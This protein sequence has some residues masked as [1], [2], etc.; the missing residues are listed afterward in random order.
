MC[1]IISFDSTQGILVSEAGAILE[2][3]DNFL[4]ERGFIM[5]LDLGAKG[6]CQIGGNVA[7]NAGGLRLLRYGS[8]HGTVLSLEVV[9]PNGT[10]VE[11]GKP[12]RKDNTGYDLKQLFIGSEGTL[13]IISKV[14]ILTPPMPKATTV[15]IV[16][17]DSYERVCQIFTKAK[18][19]LGEILSAFE[20]FDR[21][22]VD[23]VR[24]HFALREPLEQT[25]AFYVLIETHGSN[26]DHDEAKLSL[27][28]ESLLEDEAISDGVLAQD[29]EQQKLFWQIRESITEACSKEGGLYK[30]DLSVPVKDLYS[31]VTEMRKVLR[32][33]G[34]YHPEKLDSK[35]TNI[36]GFGH[37]GDGNLH[38]NINAT[39]RTYEIESQIEPF[40]YE[41]V[42]RLNGSISAEHGLGLMK[43]PFLKYSKNNSMINIMKQIKKM[44]DPKGI[45]NPY[46]YF[47]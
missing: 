29:I 46:K 27:F 47:E 39:K 36:V 5:P 19:D 3:L 24:K 10:I 33:K 6:S 13:G 41:V 43:A 9:L 34:F 38:L 1:N 28:L 18:E 26:K 23:L 44:F 45:M 21:P 20:F 4:R 7:T 22:C 16:G 42:E 31:I 25:P 11:M 12:L 35:I 2:K 14:A 30:Y 8:L 37:M 32:E 40:V 15:S 17:V